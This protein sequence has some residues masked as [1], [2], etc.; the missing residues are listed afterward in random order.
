MK[1][2]IYRDDAIRIAEQGKFKA[3]NG[4]LKNY[5]VYNL[6]SQKS[7][8]VNIVNTVIYLNPGIHKIG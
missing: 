1:E 6:N 4:N 2:M 3:M 5:V 8:I 7:S